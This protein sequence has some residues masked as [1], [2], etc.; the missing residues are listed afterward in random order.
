MAGSEG[1]APIASEPPTIRDAFL[2]GV[3]AA[4]VAGQFNRLGQVLCSGC[5][6]TW[7]EFSPAFRE[8]RLRRLTDLPLRS[9]AGGPQL[10]A[11]HPNNLLLVC[12]NCQ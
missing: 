5:G 11:D 1:A 9:Y 6:R 4:F 12:E 10:G 7:D 8:L 3:R 2:D